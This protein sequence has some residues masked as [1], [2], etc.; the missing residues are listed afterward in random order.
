M[1][2]PTTSGTDGSSPPPVSQTHTNT[3]IKLL[4]TSVSVR[5]FTGTEGDYSA[6]DIIEHCENVMRNSCIVDD[7]DKITFVRSRLEPGSPAGGGMVA[8]AFAKPIRKNY[9]GSFRTNFLIIF[10]GEAY[11]SLVKGVSNAVRSL[12]ADIAS[13]NLLESQVL[14]YRFTEDF[15]KYLRD[16]G[17]DEGGYISIENHN[18]LIELFIYML[19]VKGECRESATSLDY[20]PTEDLLDF[21]QRHKTKLEEKGNKALTIGA[22]QAEQADEGEPSYAAVAATHK[23]GVTCQYCQRER[24]TINRCYLK[25]K[26]K[27]QRK[28][29]EA[30]DGQENYK[31]NSNKGQ[32]SENLSRNQRKPTKMANTA[33]GNNNDSELSRGAGSSAPFCT[34]HQC[35]GHSTEECYSFLSL[36]KKM[37]RL[38]GASATQSGEAARPMKHKPG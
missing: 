36:Q 7:A 38:R 27:R 37:R 20:K 13:L 9:Y 15:D 35:T 29:S 5:A 6:R 4:Q 17:W 18:K 26:E 8:S 1:S 32:Q 19:S 22:T 12:V 33:S 11:R 10:A 2:N 30:V 34:L 14:A 3:P 16:N 28:K 24:H 25:R 21:V 23:G 31:S